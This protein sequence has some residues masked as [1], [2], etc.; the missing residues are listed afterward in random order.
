MRAAFVGLVSA[1]AVAFMPGTAFAQQPPSPFV[2]IPMTGTSRAGAFTGTFSIDHFVAKNGRVFAVGVLQG[3]LAGQTINQPGVEI[4]VRGQRGEGG[5]DSSGPG[6]GG[7]DIRGGF[8]GFGALT[9]E[10]VRPASSRNSAPV[11]PAQAA[12]PILNLVLGPLDLHLLGLTVHL[13]QVVLDVNAQPGQGQLLG[14]LL[15][16]VAN[17]LN[18]INFNGLLSGAI[19]NLLNS[20]TAALAGLGL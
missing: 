17:L 20:I 15:C 16:A 12:C 6:R 5:E 18:G 2:G 8:G 11:I 3:T 10:S 7:D 9:P 4:P 19:A 1:A 14:N 13:D